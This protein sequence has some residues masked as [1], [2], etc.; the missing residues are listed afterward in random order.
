MSDMVNPI[1]TTHDVEAI[2]RQ[3]EQKRESAPI[4]SNGLRSILEKYLISANIDAAKKMFSCNREEALNAIA[5]FNPEMHDIMSRRDKPRVDQSDYKTCK[6]PRGLQRVTNNTGTYFMFGNKINFTL[7]NSPEDAK[8]LEPAFDKF[9]DFLDDTYFHE[10]LYEARRITGSETECA[11]IYTIYRDEDGN[12][13]V[14]SQLKSNGN[15]DVLYPLFNQYGKMVAFAIG[16]YMR[17]EKLQQQEH[18]DVYTNKRIWKFKKNTSGTSN[19][20]ESVN[21]YPRENPI[22]KIPVIYYHHEV[23]W[24][25]SQPRIERLEW[26][27]SKRGDT[28]EYFG[29]PYLVVTADVVNNRMSENKNSD[30]GLSLADARE[31]GK[32][33]VMDSENGVFRYEAPPDSGNM[34]EN[35]KSDLKA[36]IETDT[37]T[38]DWSYKSIMGLGT[39]SG[40]AM[41]RA[42]LPGYVKRTQFTVRVYN[43][44][45]RR[46]INLIKAILCRYVYLDNAEL[47]KSIMALKINFAYTDPFIGGIEDNSTE[48][49]TLVG[50]GVMSIHAAVAAN[51]HIEDKDAEEKRIWEEYEKKALIDAKAKALA[52]QTTEQNV[53]TK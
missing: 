48:I 33:I 47:C 37:L 25:G 23:D 1:V 41:R 49:A 22:G 16:Y 12:T 8:K 32:V 38:P 44:L 30:E 50:A 28:N 53:I 18:F 11:K 9:L 45:I 36:S 24:E 29:D 7:G 27:D 13:E 43:E 15:G 35:E 4:F 2:Q 20:W 34:I 21:G 39:L 42:N 5:E 40:E 46:E 31:V 6:L 14:I 52:A 17:D 26:V 19:K 51:R 3:Q 10:K